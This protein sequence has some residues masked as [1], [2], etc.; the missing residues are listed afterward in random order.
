MIMSNI[1]FDDYVSSQHEN[2]IYDDLQLEICDDCFIFASNFYGKSSSLVTYDD[3]ENFIIERAYSVT[4]F[5]IVTSKTSWMIIFLLFTC[6][7]EKKGR[8]NLRRKKTNSCI[9]ES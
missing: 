9:R 6:K 8:S 4:K 1:I 5:C 3:D 2:V 7:I